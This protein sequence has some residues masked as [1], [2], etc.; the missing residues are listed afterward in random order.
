MEAWLSDYLAWYAAYGGGGG[1]HE[2]AAPRK[3]DTSTSG[4]LDDV[5]SPFGDPDPA[6]FF[7]SIEGDEATGDG[8]AGQGSWL[9]GIIAAEE[10]QQDGLPHLAPEELREAIQELL[11]YG[12]NRPASYHRS[13]WFRLLVGPT[14][15]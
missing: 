10:G 14:H 2:P 1:N 5:V 4:P 9:A 15:I 3:P 6:G 8:G 13:V 11:V 7:G 12:A